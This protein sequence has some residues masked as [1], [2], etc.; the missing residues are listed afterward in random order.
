MLR[1][2]TP[3]L[4][5]TSIPSAHPALPSPRFPPPH[6]LR[7]HIRLR[8]H[9]PLPRLPLLPL[10]DQRRLQLRHTPRRIALLCRQLLQLTGCG[11]R[12]SR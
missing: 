9:L 11:D 12:S 8:P 5:P 4:V 3:S 1:P 2:T 10:P 6:L 7:Q